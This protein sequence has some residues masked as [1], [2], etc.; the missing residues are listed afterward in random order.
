MASPCCCLTSSGASSTRSFTRGALPPSKT[1]SP[2]VQWIGR[3]LSDLVTGH[4]S[5]QLY[6]ILLTIEFYIILPW[7]LIF[8]NWAGKRPWLLLGAAFVVQVV[9]LALDYTIPESTAG[10]A[11][12]LG[13]F[14][15]THQDR[16]LPIYELYIIGGALAA[17]Y[18][19][20]VRA[21]V[22]RHG[23]LIVGALAV[24]LAL[25]LASFFYQFDVVHQGATYAN[26]VYQPAMAPYGLAISAFIYW[27]ALRWA[28]K[29]TPNPPRWARFW[30][31]ISDIS[32][33]IY[34][35]HAYFVD[36]AVQY[37]IPRIPRT[38]PV[39]VGAVLIY[40]MVA[41]TTVALCT[42]FLYTPG[43]SRLLGRPSAL[44]PDSRLGR[45]IAPRQAWAA[46]RLQLIVT[47]V[48]G[49]RDRDA[50]P[51]RAASEVDVATAT[52]GDPPPDGT[53]SARSS[54]DLGGGPR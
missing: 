39:P 42:L 51:T 41:I 13:L 52:T 54:A 26:S 17:L 43:L 29:R 20:Q 24:S 6:Y 1:F 40:L 18:M 27:I 9:L 53:L 3:F 25:L 8:I 46:A 21:W 7:F 48:R 10:L 19:Q 28:T 44:P 31:L 12:G 15:D 30:V 35:M 45:W 47:A 33:G 2:Q 16:F 4:A 32:F 11:T 14:I 38:W 36:L 5:W 37:V 50:G 49:R 23:A 22:L 34:L